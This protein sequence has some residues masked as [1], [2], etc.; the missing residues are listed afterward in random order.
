VRRY[1]FAENE[2]D[3]QIEI[4]DPA[5][6][7]GVILQGRIDAVLRQPISGRRCVVEIKLGQT[8]PEADLAQACLY[9]LLLTGNDP[10]PKPQDLA[11][12]TFQP[13]VHERVWRASE[14]TQPQKL[15]KDLIAKLARVKEK[16]PPVVEKKRPRVMVEMVRLLLESFDEFGAPIQLEGEPLVGPAFCRFR[17][18]PAKRIKA[19]KILN[20][21][22]TIWP[23]L[24]TDQPPQI[25]MEHG[26]IAIDVQRPDREVLHWEARLCPSPGGSLGEVSSL[27]VGRNV[28]GE[29]KFADLGAPEHAHFLVTGTTGSGKTEWLR[30]V[31][32]SLCTANTPERLSLVLIDPKRTAFAV[33]TKS[34]FLRRP[35][36]FPSDEDILRVLDNLVEEMERRFAAMEK[37]QVKDLKQY[38]EG[39]T[40]PLPRVVCICDEYADLV[41]VD[42]RRGKEVERRIGRLGAKGRAAGIHLILATQRP[43]RDVVRGVIR[44]NMNARVALHVNERLE[45]RIV[46]EQPGAE[47]LLGKGDLLFKDLG[48][49][50]RLQAPLISDADL[51]KAAR[52]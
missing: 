29:W 13:E 36:V 14:L 17:A 11:L 43:S 26:L 21:A 5:W 28:E 4:T 27:P 51:K 38:N 47:T 19:D 45:S 35:M 23:R 7:E 42:S 31:V 44:A 52:C 30:M 39:Q 46:I 37:M 12:L 10:S 20:M 25:T 6:T 50:V 34:P 22:T 41:L 33:L 16:E 24:K 9:H 1:I 48:P 18:K 15:L 32:G 49:A 3:C 8:H 2:L 40:K